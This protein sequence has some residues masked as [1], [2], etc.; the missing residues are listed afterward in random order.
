MMKRCNAHIVCWIY[1][2]FSVW[3]TGI[4]QEYYPKVYSAKGRIDEQTVFVDVRFDR[5]IKVKRSSLLADGNS[6]VYISNTF[7]SE[8]GISLSFPYAIQDIIS[9][10][11]QHCLISVDGQSPRV[12]LIDLLGNVL[13]TLDLPFS[14]NRKKSIFLGI[15]DSLAFIVHDDNVF[16]ISF[17]KNL[18]TSRLLAD[19]TLVTQ[20]FANGFHCI[21]KSGGGHV[22]RTV[23]TKGNII[24]E[25][26][27]S[28]LGVSYSIQS[29][30]H[31]ILVLSTATGTST[32]AFLLDINTGKQTMMFFPGTLKTI[33]MWEKDSIPMISWLT[34]ND[35]SEKTIN[36]K[37]QGGSTKSITIPGFFAKTLSASGNGTMLQYLFDNGICLINCNALAIESA[38]RIGN[39]K[40]FSDTDPHLIMFKSDKIIVSP[41][42]YMMLSMVE[43]PFWWLRR[44][45]ETSGKLLFLGLICIVIFLSYRHYSRQKRFLEAGLELSGMG[46]ILYL[47][48]EGR[49]SKV[50]STAKS[51]LQLSSDVPLHR[52]IRYY[53]NK[54]HMAEL[55]NFFQEAFQARKPM[56]HRI[57]LIDGDSTKE[58][59]WSTTPLFGFAGTFAG[60]I[61]S[62]IDITAEL[63][64]KRLTNWAQLAH[65][66]QTN[67]SI[68]LLNAQQLQII[69]EKNV[70]RQRKILG[71][72]TLLMQRVR[73]IVTVGRDEDAQLSLND[74]LVICRN[75]IQEFDDQLY[76]NAH[77]SYGGKQVMFLCDPIKLTRGLRNAVENG[78]RALQKEE[79]T[80]DLSCGFDD[81]HV[82]F[83]IK[84]SGIGMDEF[85]RDNMMKPYFTTK[86]SHGGYGIGTMVMQK[87]AELHNGRI[88]IMSEPGKG[89]IITFTIPKLIS[90]QSELQ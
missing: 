16:G 9:I 11:K 69:D 89:T 79:G 75:V 53:V 70:Q 44:F 18:L 46:L 84:D 71:Q 20:H 39:M 30:N 65:D 64:K 31:A 1:I 76:P 33:A 49:L 45:A 36:I 85:T 17:T 4:A 54:P 56:Q 3:T 15:H 23:N 35:K 61:F 10:D 13:S 6:Q 68:I 24:R 67:L 78:I 48:N 41:K 51:V 21:R 2:F 63:E 86:K 42:G 32:N 57:T 72:I 8:N 58:Y 80:V 83:R 59:I 43:D 52:P 60:C 37:Q 90:E 7:S 77:L 73:D 81:S 26:P 74:A 66:M 55:L 38:S 14:S 29:T 34:E 22:L 87:V 88:D 28:P 19:E 50:N 5:V 62:G 27:F 82:Y 47:D 40:D 25:I 12:L